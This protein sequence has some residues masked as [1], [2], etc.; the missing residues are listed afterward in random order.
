M[1]VLRKEVGI[2]RVPVIQGHCTCLTPMFGLVD[3][4]TLGKG[5]V[6]FHPL[7]VLGLEGRGLGLKD[8]GLCV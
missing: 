1:C 8:L 6:E 2:V 5:G 4:V 3:L 7:R